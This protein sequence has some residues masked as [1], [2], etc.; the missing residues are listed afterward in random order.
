LTS[1]DL[2]QLRSYLPAA[3][4]AAL[5]DD[6]AAPSP[7][8]LADCL[9]QLTN[10]HAAVQTHLPQL[11]LDRVLRDPSPG[12]NDGQFI[13]G[14]L[15]FADIS[16]FTAMSERLSRIG[17]EGAEEITGIVNRYFGA[18]LALLRQHDGQLMQFGGDALL[19]LFLEPGSAVR[20]VQAALAMQAAMLDFAHT[21]T[22]Q[23]TFLLQM[24]VGIHAGRFFLAQLGTAQGME[25]ALF[26]RDV[27]MA[28]LAEAAASAGQVVATRQT[29]DTI[30]VSCLADPL[31]EREGYFSVKQLAGPI[32]P[33][34]PATPFENISDLRQEPTLEQ[35]RGVVA[36][37]NALTP[38][39]PA[40]L[41]PRIGP[42]SQAVSAQG[43]HRLVAVL[44]A[45]VH[46]LS[47]IADRLGEGRENQICA[48]FNDYVTA[49]AEA[50]HRYEGVINKIDLAEHG[51]KLLVFFGA[52]QAHEDDAERAVRA[53]LDMQAALQTLTGEAGGL[54]QK[55]GISYGYVFAGYVGTAWRHEYTVMGD[56]VNLA[57]RLMAAAALGDILVTSNVWL[58]VRSRF[59]LDPRGE[60]HVKGKSQPIPIFALRAPRPVPEPV[61]GLAGMN[62]PLLGREVERQHLRAAVEQVLLGRGQIVSVMGEAGLGKSRLVAELHQEAS[63]QSVQ[64]IEGHCLSYTEAVSYWLFKEVLRQLMGWQP[65]DSETA[66]WH[67][68][69]ELLSARLSAEEA[70]AAL[71]YLAHFLGL[72][73]DPAAHER[74]RLLDAEALQRRT[75]VVYSTLLEASARVP[76]QPLVL[77][78]DD[79]HWLDRASLDLLNHLLP[80]VARVPLLLVLL[81]RL[82]RDKGCWQIR[83][84]A[85]RDFGYCSTEIMLQRLSTAD[86]RELVNNLLAVDQLPSDFYATVLSRIDGNPLYLEEVIRALIND[87]TLVRDASGKWTLG[88]A[89]DTIKVPDTVQGVMM[90]R[91]DQLEEPSRRMVQLAS[92]IGRTFAFDVLS[93]VAADRSDQVNACVIRLQ[94]RELVH[95]TQHVPDI[96]YAFRHALLQEVCYDSLLARTRQAYHRAIAE[97]LVTHRSVSHSEAEAAYPLVAHH[98]FAGQDWPR[99]LHYQIMAGQHAMRLFANREAIDH[100][101]KALQSA[102]ELARAREGS[103]PQIDGSRQLIHAAL[104]ELLTTIGQ[105]AP[106]E[107]H[108][109]EAQA[110]AE[111][112]GDRDAQARACRW[113]A[114]LHQLRGEFPAAFAW[115]EQ[116]QAVLNERP[117][118]EAAQ[119][120]LVAGLIHSRQGHYEHALSECRGILNLAHDLNE[121]AVLARTHNLIG[122]VHRLQGQGASA[123]DS[124]RQALDLYE[125]AGDIHGQAT[126]H[127]LIATACLYL[128]QLHEAAQHAHASRV[129]FDRLDDLYNRAF[130]DNNLGEIL[131][132]RGDLDEAL[133]VYTTALQTLERIGAAAYARGALHNNLGAALIRQRQIDAARRHLHTSASLFAQIEGRD[134]L[135]ELHRHFAEA[136]LLADELEEAATES[137]AALAL[138]RELSMRG[139]E[140]STLRVLGEIALARRQP[141]EAR[142]YLDQSLIVLDEVGDE[143][144]AARTRLSLARCYGSQQYRAEARTMLARSLA[145]FQRLEAALDL[146]E[147]REVERTLGGA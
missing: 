66:A 31:P 100:F 89:L 117:T 15:L 67:R 90:T 138:S 17:R 77:V 58:K 142:E 130:A 18:M 74:I 11:V 52:P 137:Q 143:Y 8:L 84:R 140:G 121:P 132:K 82:E 6:S 88:R 76:G 98:A 34:R 63:A 147:A 22:S 120:R 128:G 68:L 85:A 96:V 2:D 122:H 93:H 53:A 144:E 14:T 110:L 42:E 28:A 72:R 19:G 97:Y 131:L 124:F 73:L 1:A 57:A 39:L 54:S 61:R 36:R 75:F 107:Q 116:G 29:L 94:Q 123:L 78:L 46:G 92:V 50:I 146:A 45:N 83:E 59:E 87:Q 20:A 30:D 43:E 26:G 4:D 21:E 37:L 79:L 12:R 106:A 7:A 115:I 108:L 99:A 139:E 23:G 24:K 55:I 40:G 33:D 118:S 109:T 10:L 127:N 9:Q 104:G 47:E 38:Y 25:Y 114:W 134:F 44:F 141:A 129:I 95:E 49:M 56:E 80:L 103:P 41:L 65:G 3:L 111:T 113:L 32:A 91:L 13:R 69:R 5:R 86:T 27:N 112:R 145:V 133:A 51:D 105:F 81:Y 71:P 60:V 70:N 35:V 119:L 101:Q 135:P 126:T 62:S 125:Q 48:T 16:G 64:W 102:Y 136:A